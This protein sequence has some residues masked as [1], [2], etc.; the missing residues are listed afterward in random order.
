[1]KNRLE[2]S[3]RGP[4][5]KA[6]EVIEDIPAGLVFRSVGY[7]GVA[8]PGVPFDERAG[9]ILNDKGRVLD[10]ETKRARVG[11]YA[12]GWIKRGPSGVIG[13]N[14]PDAG[15]TVTLMLEDAAAG[16]TLTPSAGDAAAIERLV[17]DRQP[18]CVSYADWK[19]LDRLEVERGRP[20]GR[21]RVKYCT[22]DE[23]QKALGR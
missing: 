6:T 5:A 9:V 20:A 1:M 3:D 18:R 23:I 12:A 16:A 21:P 7:K 22:V 4:Q 8:L 10:P 11:E 14:K 15:E 17:R 13:T 19:T 2:A